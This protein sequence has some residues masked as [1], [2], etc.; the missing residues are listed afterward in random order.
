[1]G[2]NYGVLL[3]RAWAMSWRHRFLWVLALFAGGGGG[4]RC[5]VP[6][7]N[8]NWPGS[9]ANGFG[10]VAPEVGSALAEPGRWVAQHL[11]LLVALGAV[12][13]LF[14]L[15]MLAIGLLCQGALAR[16]T[17]DLAL[18]RPSRLGLAWRAG[19]A[20][21]WRYVGLALILFGLVFGVL[22]LLAVLVGLGALSYHLSGGT[23]GPPLLVGGILVGVVVVL[24]MIPLLIAV[25]IVVELAQRAIVVEDLGPRRALVSGY[26]LFRANLGPALIVWLISVGLAIGYGFAVLV[27]L[28]LLVLPLGLIGALFYFVGGGFSTGLIVYGSSAVVVLVVVLILLGALSNTYLWS[29]WTLAYLRLRG[30]LDLNLAPLEPP[31]AGADA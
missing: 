21:F 31:L 19:C 5:S 26:H 13:V 30:D 14:V 27:G 25:G 10:Q 9:G 20:L 15:A 16:A 28:L 22:M 2:V 11:G 1:V 8:F 23:L 18:G 24:L 7:G 12:L 29:Y 6:S 4:G 3:R 17:V